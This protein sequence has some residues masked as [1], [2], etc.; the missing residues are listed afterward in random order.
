MAGFPR[1][2]A[3]EGVNLNAFY[4]KARFT[5]Q[6]KYIAAGGHGGVFASN[7]TRTMQENQFQS[8]S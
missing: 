1:T 3:Y 8:R 2:K 4:P 5:E 7:K 6:L